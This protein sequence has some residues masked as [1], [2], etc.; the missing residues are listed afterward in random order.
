MLLFVCFILLFFAFISGFILSILD[1]FVESS[2]GSTFAANSTASITD[3]QGN[4]WTIMSAQVAKN[5]VV[6]TT[7]GGVIRLSYVNAQV[8][9]EVSRP[10]FFRSVSLLPSF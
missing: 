3:A 5:G 1:Q 4:A 2:C 8:W 10:P 7:T 9:Q 6:D